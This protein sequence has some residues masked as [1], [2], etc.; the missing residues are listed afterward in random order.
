METKTCPSCGADVPAVANTCKHC[1]H[2]FNAV[3]EK[4]TN[5][6]VIL[7]ATLLAMAVVGAGLFAHKYYY[8]ATE[9][10]VVDGETKSI[11]ITKVTASKT[12]TDRIPFANVAKIEHVMGGEKAMYEVVA[13]TTQG[14]RI[15]VQQSDKPIRGHAEHVANIVD[16]PFEE[17]RNIK[18]FGD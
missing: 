1:F 2:D 13:V 17:V 6:L 3:V 11:V 16:K 18:G 9:S 5:P 7:L 8:N 14:E 10:I 15:I 4:K 12:T